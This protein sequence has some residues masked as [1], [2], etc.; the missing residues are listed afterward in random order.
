MPVEDAGDK[1]S[2]WVVGRHRFASS[3]HPANAALLLCSPLLW[4]HLLPW[5]R[6]AGVVQDRLWKA[7]VS[8]SDSKTLDNPVSRSLLKRL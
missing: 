8:H 6:E 5:D 1:D 3:L 7:S 4:T 2:S